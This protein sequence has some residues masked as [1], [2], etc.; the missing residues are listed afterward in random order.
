MVCCASHRP[1]TSTFLARY[2]SK[3]SP[4]ALKLALSLG[5]WE[6][7]CERGALRGVAALCCAATI[8]QP[9][10]ARK[11]GSCIIFRPKFLHYFLF[12]FIIYTKVFFF[13]FISEYAFKMQML[14]IP[15]VAVLLPRVC[16]H[17]SAL[18]I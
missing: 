5:A 11:R 2:L 4:G 7:H 6:K 17:E 18:L 8:V 1:T 15:N 9:I 10:H 3:D 16:V 13:E 12:C 14:H